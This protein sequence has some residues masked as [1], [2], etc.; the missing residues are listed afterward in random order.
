MKTEIELARLFNTL[1][2]WDTIGTDTQYRIL[3]KED[4][5]IIIF[6]PSNSKADW[7]INFNFPKR[8]YK[9]MPVPFYVHGGFLKEWKKIN[10]YFLKRAGGINKPITVVGWSY[11]GALATLCYED[12]W[13][14]NPFKRGSMRLVTFGSPRVVGALH[15]KKVAHRWLGARILSNGSDLVTSLPPRLLGF[16]HIATPKQI[17]D[18]RTLFGFFKTNKYHQIDS[19][20]ESMESLHGNRT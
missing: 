18:K 16:K 1:T 19:Y 15:F 7:K 5:V 9:R 3:E 10:D 11:G 14:N 8:P 6:Y 12:I 17:G 13:F 2:D 4:E 20:I